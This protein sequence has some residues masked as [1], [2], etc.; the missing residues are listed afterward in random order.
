MFDQILNLI[1]ELFYEEL[2]SET[3]FKIWWS[4]H[5]FLFFHVYITANV[6]ILFDSREIFLDL[7]GESISISFFKIYRIVIPLPRTN[8]LIRTRIESIE[9][10]HPEQEEDNQ[11]QEEIFQKRRSVLVVR[12][13]TT[14][15]KTLDIEMQNLDWNRIKVDIEVDIEVDMEHGGG[16]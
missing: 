11:D 15:S 6:Y 13:T 10:I 14:I 16:H 7:T 2:G 12:E 5:L 1:V 3:V 8:A 9:R 4:F